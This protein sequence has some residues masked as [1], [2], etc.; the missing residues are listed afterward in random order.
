VKYAS[1]GRN[2]IDFITTDGHPRNELAN[3]VYHGYIRHESTGRY[4]VYR[5]DGTRLGDLGRRPTSPYKASDF[6]TLLA[7]DAVSPVNHLRMTRGW[8]TD[9]AL[10]RHDRPYAVFTARVEDDDADHRFFYAR[11]D[12]ETWH[13]HELAKAG[14]YL[15]ERENDYTGLAA[16]DPRDPNRLFISTK[17]DPQTDEPLPH[18]EL[19]D[20]TTTDG[21]AT[22]SWSPVTAHSTAD[23]LRPI[24]PQAGADQTLLLW[25]RG[26]YRT[27]TDYNMSI[28]GLTTI[29]PGT[30]GGPGHRGA[31]SR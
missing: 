19:F 14:G 25:M 8:T 11:F 23:N 9:L 2:R 18:Y 5:S 24:V 27:Y 12:G 29:V 30:T 21:G 7:A 22:W 4:A 17:L 15:Y 10:D 16:L 28:V 6:T 20:G 1:N 26:T 31:G 3:G 13:I